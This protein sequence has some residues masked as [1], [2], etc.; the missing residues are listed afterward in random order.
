MIIRAYLTMNV[1]DENTKQN[2]NKK[3]TNCM[4]FYKMLKI[5]TLTLEE[6]YTNIVSPFNIFIEDI[7]DSTQM[8]VMFYRKYMASNSFYRGF[9]MKKNT[10]GNGSW[11]RYLQNHSIQRN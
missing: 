10:N 4:S 9:L 1:N 11:C 2:T 6:R 3:T 8:N 7:F 5:Y